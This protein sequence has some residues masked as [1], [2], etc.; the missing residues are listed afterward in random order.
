MEKHELFVRM[1]H[2]MELR[3]YSQRTIDNYLAA[4]TKLTEFYQ[5]SPG[6]ISSQQ[7][8]DYLHNRLIHDAIST[9]VINQYISAFKILQ[10]DVLKRDWEQ[11]KIKRPRRK[12]TLPVVLTTGEIAN[13]I[14]LTRNLKHKA[15]IS[16]AYSSGMR[17]GELQMLN[18]EDI[19][20]GRGQIRIRNGKGKKDRYAL[21]SLKVL[22]ML[23]TYYKMYHPN[24]YLFESGYKAAKPLALTTLNR[25]VKLAAER[26]KIKKCISFHTLRHC[27]ATH[28]LEKGVNLRVIQQL[29][30]HNSLKTTAVYLHVANIDP[31]SVSSPF[32]DLVL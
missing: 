1:V 23:R 7:V 9:S 15:I 14:T 6:K 26:A 2:E 10:Q 22:E 30:G 31:H 11:I 16:L 20:S 21:L 17:K 32:D 13:M 12:K 4:T 28:M 19:D 27:F 29:M 25:I 18:P 5:L 24:T 8:K 3:N